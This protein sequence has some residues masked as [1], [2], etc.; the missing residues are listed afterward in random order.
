LTTAAVFRHREPDDAAWLLSRQ[1]HIYA[2][3]AQEERRVI[4]E[5][6]RAALAAAKAR[7]TKLGNP[8]IA[9]AGSKGVASFPDSAFLT[10]KQSRGR[11][12]RRQRPAD[13]RAA[14]GRGS[15]PAEDRRGVERSRHCHGARRRMDLSANRQRS[16]ARLAASIRCDA[17]SVIAWRSERLAARAPFLCAANVHGASTLCC[18]SRS[19]L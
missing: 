10:D 7:G 17:E 3:V 9:E 13:H 12:F 18:P 19:A 1:L 15:E 14:E 4:S 5:R 6:T 11:S 8:R 2:A 16:Q